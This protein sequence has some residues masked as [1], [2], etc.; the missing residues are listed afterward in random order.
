MI[1]QK[2]GRHISRKIKL[3]SLILSQGKETEI[4]IVSGCPKFAEK[5][6][7]ESDTFLNNDCIFIKCIVAEIFH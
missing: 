3:S 7:L 4:T 1:D 6:V 2:E 5:T